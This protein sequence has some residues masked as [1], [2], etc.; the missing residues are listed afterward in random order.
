MLCKYCGEDKPENKFEV[1]N[2]VK[3][4]VYRRR[5]CGVCKTKAQRIRRNSIRQWFDEYKTELGCAN[6]GNTDMRCLDF[7]HTDPTQKEQNLSN[8][9]R[10]GWGKERILREAQ[11]CVILCAN[12]H[13]IHHYNERNGV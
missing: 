1:A 2:V 9:I 6:C 5:K 3:G 4:K 13:R 7:H 10:M 8:I 12:C 11:K